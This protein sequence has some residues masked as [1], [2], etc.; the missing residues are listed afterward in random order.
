MPKAA[1]A[2]GMVSFSHMALRVGEGGEVPGCAGNAW[3][4]QV[5]NDDG[6]LS[7]SLLP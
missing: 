1:R 7:C 2:M 6:R 5:A 3:Q 4:R